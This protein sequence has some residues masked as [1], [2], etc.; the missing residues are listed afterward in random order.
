MGTLS[1]FFI[2]DSKSFASYSTGADF[3]DSDRCQAKRITP[4]EAANLLAVLRGHGDPLELINEFP[5]LTPEDDEHW[6]FAVPVD[7]IVLLAALSTASVAPHAAAFAKATEEELGWSE[8]EAQPFLA[9]LV[10][11]AQRAKANGK[12]MFLWLSL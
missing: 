5:M 1:D 12:A 10:A 6:T 3:P 2:A 7:F 4:L 9:E 11:L 8:S